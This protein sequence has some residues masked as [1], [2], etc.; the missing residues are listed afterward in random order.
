MRNTRI[1]IIKKKLVHTHADNDLSF[2]RITV[3]T[4]VLK[5]KNQRK[6]IT[7]TYAP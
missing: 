5:N 4:S 6:K 7:T 1:I 3:M 2:V